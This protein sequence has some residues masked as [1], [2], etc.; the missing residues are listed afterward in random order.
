MTRYG[1][2]SDQEILA[3][4]AAVPS[5]SPTTVERFRVRSGKADVYRVDGADPG[6]SLVLKLQDPRICALEERV[7]REV[8]GRLPVPAIRCHGTVPSHDPSRAWMVM[9]YADGVP[10]DTRS[11]GHTTSLARWLGAVHSGAA[12]VAVPGDFPDHGAAY[13]HEVVAEAHLTLR[14]AVE[15]PAV[16]QREREGL[17]S[18][19]H[20]LEGVLGT[21]LGVTPWMEAVPSTLTHGDLVPQNIKVGGAAVG[22]FPQVHDWGTAGWGCPMIDLLHVDLAAYAES[23][24]PDWPELPPTAAQVLRALGSVCW[25][26]FVLIGERENLSSPWPH[27]AA[28]KVPVYLRELEGYGLPLRAGALS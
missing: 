9:D 11:S 17:V 1:L 22:P 23:L 15:N 18:L 20:V 14:T 25:T 6:V 3:A 13:W 19:A 24:G 16:T 8:L 26:A 27:R 5:F 21:W 12:R 10:F 28:A 2:P 7:Y 4:A